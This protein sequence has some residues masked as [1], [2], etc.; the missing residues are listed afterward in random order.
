MS[1][2]QKDLIQHAFCEKMNRRTFHWAHKGTAG[3]TTAGQVGVNLRH[4]LKGRWS[5]QAL[6]GAINVTRRQR[7]LCDEKSDRGWMWRIHG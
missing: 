3:F 7:R 1:L 5:T 2:R 6:W 4:R